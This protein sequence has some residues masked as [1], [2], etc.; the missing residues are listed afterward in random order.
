[1]TYVFFVLFNLIASFIMTNL[2]LAVILQGFT[3]SADVDS[4]SLPPEV[5]QSLV[6]IWADFDP[7]AN[8][9]IK[10]KDVEAFFVKLDRK[11]RVLE[12]PIS[13]ES[14]LWDLANRGQVRANTISSC[15][16]RSSI[17]D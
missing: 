17:C 16:V 3:E 10:C 5:F 1:M 14:K 12:R 2:F 9:H 4:T 15:I 6:R 7:L 13:N 8:Y 11:L